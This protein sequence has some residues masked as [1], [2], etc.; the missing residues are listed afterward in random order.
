MRNRGFLPISLLSLALAAPVLL[1]GASPVE[2]AVKDQQDKQEK[3]R[4]QQ[5]RQRDDWN[6]G[7]NDNDDWDRDWDDSDGKMRFQGMDTNK[8]G[9]VTR[10]EWRGNARSF[11]QHDWNRDG[12]LSGQE[13]RPGG[14]R[15]DPRAQ[16]DDD[17]WDNDRR[18]DDRFE[19]LDRNNDRYLSASEWPRDRRGFDLLDR[20]NDR[21]VSRSEFQNRD[22]DRRE[23]LEER[24][25]EMDGNRDG[26]LSRSEWWGGLTAFERLDRNDDRYLSR[27]EF[28]NRDYDRRDTREERFA[29]MD[30]NRDGR[31]SRNEW[32]SGEDTFEQLDR[33]NDQYISRDELL[34]RDWNDRNDRDDRDGDL[35]PRDERR[36]QDLDRSRDGRLSRTEWTGSR[37]FFDRLDRNDD[38][39]LSLNEW[40]ER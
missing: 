20:N 10:R 39:W 5:N 23:L 26:R 25:A 12:V 33:N 21:R 13:V 8:D 3:N 11:D 4:G 29:E 37:D 15:N 31:L 7:W 1:P 22:F 32:T 14:S 28:L 36:F 35:Y 34:N 18:D 24:F 27:S 40:L 16:G 19:D 38:G 30:T 9:R 17:R 6:N 2:A